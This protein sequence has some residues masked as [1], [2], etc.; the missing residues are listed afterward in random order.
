MSLAKMKQYKFII[1]VNYENWSHQG[2]SFKQFLMLLLLNQK[3][4]LFILA[5][6][7]DHIWILGNVGFS[8]LKRILPMIYISKSEYAATFG[9]PNTPSLAWLLIPTSPPAAS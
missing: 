2:N 4:V 8:Q 1:F 5:S 9:Y 6:D 3:Q 7:S